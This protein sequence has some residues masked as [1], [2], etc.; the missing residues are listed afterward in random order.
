MSAARRPLSSG[1]DRRLRSRRTAS[2]APAALG[3]HGDAVVARRAALPHDG[4]D[5]GRAGAG[6]APAPWSRRLGRPG[7]P[8]GRHD[9]D[10]LRRRTPDP[11]GRVRHERAR[12]ARHRRDPT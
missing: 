4:D 8:A 11:G 7:R 5:P 10:G 9:P 2:R 3:R 1:H 6:A 12:G